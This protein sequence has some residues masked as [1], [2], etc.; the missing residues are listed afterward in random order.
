M[1]RP[2]ITEGS[3]VVAREAPALLMMTGR[4]YRDVEHALDDGALCRIKVE[5]NWLYSLSVDALETAYGEVVADALSVCSRWL[6][7]ALPHV[8]GKVAKDLVERPVSRDAAQVLLRHALR[9]GE[10]TGLPLLTASY[11]PYLALYNPSDV[12]EVLAI[13]HSLPR[14]LER[15]G[16]VRGRDLEAPARRPAL[17]TWRRLV[18]S[19]GEFLG[20][21]WMDEDTLVGWRS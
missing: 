16:A 4:S 10:L 6:L 8:G 11:Q 15:Q 9:K 12:D 13:V 21:G 19:H 3:V 1:A 18:L 14:L 17:D 2:E 5:A 20:L 7:G